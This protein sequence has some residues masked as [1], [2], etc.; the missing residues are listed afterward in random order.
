MFGIF[1]CLFQITTTDTTSTIL[2]KEVY[3]EDSGV[4]SVK[5]ENRGGT[6][7]SSANLVVEGKKNQRDLPS[8]FLVK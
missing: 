7:K 8:F 6:A 3:L 1:F 4:F 5:A 2:I